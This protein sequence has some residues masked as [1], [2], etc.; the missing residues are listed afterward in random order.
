MSFIGTGLSYLALCATALIALV[1]VVVPLV[2]GSQTYSVLTSS[3]APHYAPGTF[4]VV[5]PVPFEELRV[6]DVITYQIESND[7]AVI[8]HRIVSVGTAQDGARTLITQGDN[9]DVAD[10]N[11]VREIQVRG[12]LFYAVPFVGFAA[13]AL[14]NSDRGAAL[15]WGA[16]AL[17]GYG[18]VTMVRGALA[19]R[20]EDGE[21]GDAG[22]GEP[23]ND[24]D[25]AG[26]ASES[27]PIFGTLSLDRDD[28][29]DD[30]V[31]EEC[32]HCTHGSSRQHLRS[33]RKPVAV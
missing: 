10:E 19:K 31:L 8:T 21:T 17:L 32:E 33:H 11:P 2:T 22:S 29:E 23:G 14:G 30:P 5:K 4:L 24:S 13:N 3:M 1:L 28:M 6:G 7:P 26:P 27:N 12:K 15:Q 20:R 25:G 9:N 18:V 16:V